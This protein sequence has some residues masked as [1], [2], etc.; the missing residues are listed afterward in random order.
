MAEQE[1]EKTIIN[2]TQVK[3]NKKEKQILALG[4]SYCPKTDF[5]YANTRMDID[6]FV[7][8]LKLQKHFALQTQTKDTSGGEALALE[9]A[10]ETDQE[11]LETLISLQH[12][13]G[14][15]GDTQASPRKEK[16]KKLPSKRN[17]PLH[18][19]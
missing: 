13:N 4:L 11:L 5:D 8:K 1:V 2:L 19:L 6:K 17:Q 12:E 3:L 16:E 10:T 14:E 7:R 18:P 15:S 9:I